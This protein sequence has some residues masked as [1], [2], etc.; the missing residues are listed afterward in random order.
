MMSTKALFGI[1]RLFDWINLNEKKYDITKNLITNNLIKK[2]TN[3]FTNGKIR[4]NL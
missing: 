1:L 4:L 3:E 2:K